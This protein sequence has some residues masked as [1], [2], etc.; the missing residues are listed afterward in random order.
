MTGSD[1]LAKM[2]ISLP[3]YNMEEES[4]IS[5]AKDIHS[6][7]INGKCLDMY[8]N[9]YLYDLYNGIHLESPESKLYIYDEKT[10]NY[11]LLSYVQIMQFLISGKCYDIYHNEIIIKKY[12]L[13]QLRKLYLELTKRR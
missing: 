5:L 10:H 3:Y 12:T 11:I 2:L 4:V 6:I 8:R 13:M 9:I 1:L 7:S